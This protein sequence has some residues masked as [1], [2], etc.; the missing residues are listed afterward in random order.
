MAGLSVS[1]FGLQVSLTRF[2]IVLYYTY[3]LTRRLCEHVEVAQAVD[4]V[5]RGRDRVLALEPRAV[6]DPCACGEEQACQLPNVEFNGP[7]AHGC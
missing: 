4:H 7:H 2:R 3:H 5:R 6:I 1:R